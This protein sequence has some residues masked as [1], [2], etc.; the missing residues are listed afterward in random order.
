MG[1]VVKV[2]DLV[3]RERDYGVLYDHGLGIIISKQLA[4]SNPVHA[5]IT[6]LYPKIGKTYDIAESLVE[7]ISESR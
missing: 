1:Y 6:V 3:I 2:G 4:G 5:C 7:V